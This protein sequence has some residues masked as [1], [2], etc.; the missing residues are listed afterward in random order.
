MPQNLRSV[1]PTNPALFRLLNITTMATIGSYEPSQTEKRHI[2]AKQWP[3]DMTDRRAGTTIHLARAVDKAC[4]DH[5]GL[6]FSSNFLE[7]I[8]PIAFHVIAWA[9]QSFQRRRG[10][11]DGCESTTGLFLLADTL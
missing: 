3:S 1:L 4:V 8:H 5:R 2:H 10:D 9:L 6:S 7:L 11:S